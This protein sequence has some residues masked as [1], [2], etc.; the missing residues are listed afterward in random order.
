M[1][2]NGKIERGTKE[3]YLRKQHLLRLKDKQEN[4]KRNIPPQAIESMQ[5]RESLRR[6]LTNLSTR[7]NALKG[8]GELL[9]LQNVDHTEELKRQMKRLEVLVK[10]IKR[11]EKDELEQTHI[12]ETTKL[13]KSKG[14]IL[15]IYTPYIKTQSYH[16][17]TSPLLG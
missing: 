6:D 1:E 9:A 4:F 17:L 5:Q 13:K 7:L 11:L 12:V 16:D 15:P 3:L 10:Q 14:S 8:E 2:L